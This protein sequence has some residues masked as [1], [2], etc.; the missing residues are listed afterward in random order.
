MEKFKDQEFLEFVVKSIV[1]NPDSVKISRVIDE[2]GVLL[3][4]DVAQEDVARI[5]GRQGQTAKAIRLLLRTVG[6]SQKVRANLR[7][8]APQLNPT[9]R[10]PYQS[11]YKNV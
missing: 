10:L 5:I 7:I 2:M 1:S 6:Y 4:L 3:T 11:S 9:S 8:N